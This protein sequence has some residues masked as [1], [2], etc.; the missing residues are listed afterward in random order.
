MFCILL[1]GIT[2]TSTPKAK[3]RKADDQTTTQLHFADISNIER[4]E[5]PTTHSVRTTTTPADVHGDQIEVCG[6]QPA[7]T[8]AD[9]HSDQPATAPADVHGDQSATTRADVRSDQPATTPVDVRRNVCVWLVECTAT[10][11]QCVKKWMQG[12]LG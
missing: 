11:S 12:S 6:D 1:K 7:T 9:V 4:P 8:P 10:Y 5:T 2:V 3:V